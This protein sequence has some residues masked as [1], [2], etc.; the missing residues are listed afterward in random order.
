MWFH[1]FW[2][3]FDVQGGP[4]I[5]HSE[6]ADD[7]DVDFSGKVGA[8]YAVAEATSV[9]GELSGATDEDAAGES[10]VNWGAKAG[11]KFTF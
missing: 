3:T 1:H 2:I 4:A 10:L 9:Y 5:N 8:S 11:I 7:T 6:A